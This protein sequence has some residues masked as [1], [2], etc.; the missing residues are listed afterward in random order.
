M[1]YL[2]YGIRDDCLRALLSLKGAHQVISNQIFQKPSHLPRECQHALCLISTKLQRSPAYLQSTTLHFFLRTFFPLSFFINK[3]YYTLI[4]K[5]GS[6]SAVSGSFDPMD[7]NPPGFI[8]NG[9]SQARILEQVANSY[10]RGSSQLRDQT[11]ISCISC[12]GRRI[13]LSMYESMFTDEYTVVMFLCQEC[14]RESVYGVR[15]L[16]LNMCPQNILDRLYILWNR[17]ISLKRLM[18]VPK[19]KGNRK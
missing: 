10:S 12:I 5:L 16:L 14:E 3:I 19:I 13:Y 2:K 9:I 11:H 4:Y 7:C 1:H 6:P 8:N 18:D 17:S 15:M